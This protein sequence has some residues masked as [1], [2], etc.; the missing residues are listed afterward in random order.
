M[1]VMLYDHGSNTV[2]AYNQYRTNIT[3][4]SYRH[5]GNIVRAWIGQRSVPT[6]TGHNIG[7]CAHTILCLCDILFVRPCV[8]TIL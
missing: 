3:D 6:V 5:R 8:C 7:S 4:I 1:Q 2:R